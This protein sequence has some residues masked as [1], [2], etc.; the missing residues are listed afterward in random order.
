MSLDSP[1][2]SIDCKKE[3]VL[4]NVYRD[5]KCDAQ[6]QVYAHDYSHLSAGKVIP[7]GI[8]DLQRNEG[9]ITP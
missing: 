7:Y 5:G 8:Y 3:D 2:L 4:G 6:G 1:I 9:Y